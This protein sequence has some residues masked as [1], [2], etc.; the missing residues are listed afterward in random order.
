M[1]EEVRKDLVKEPLLDPTTSKPWYQLCFICRKGIDFKKST[2]LKQKPYIRVGSMV[3]H[4]KCR[5]SPIKL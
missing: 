1:V 2:G 3:R 4:S 5:P